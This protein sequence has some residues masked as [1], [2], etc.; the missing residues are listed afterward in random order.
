MATDEDDRR[1][2]DA[3][4][5]KVPAPERRVLKALRALIRA[6]VPGATERISYQVPMFFHDGGLVAWAAGK[7]HLSFFVMSNAVARAMADELGPWLG[8]KTT[9]HFTA[10]RPLPAALVKRIVRARLAENGQ[11][12]AKRRR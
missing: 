11:R 9:L 12:A 5:A 3:Y 4:L 8:A 7:K 2:V 10:Q 6:Q 1:A